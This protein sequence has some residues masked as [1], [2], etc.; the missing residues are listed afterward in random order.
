MQTIRQIRGFVGQLNVADWVTMYRI[1]AAPIMV[2]AIINGSLDLFKWLIVTSLASDMLDGFIARRLKISSEHGASL[3]S[4]GDA[5]LFVIALIGI[6]RF[7]S[8]FVAEN[9]VI[10]SFALNPY[11]FQ[12]G[13]AFW[14]YGKPSSF[15]TYMAK[16][17]AIFQGSLILF[18]LFFGINYWLFY[19]TLI[20]SILETVEEII[21]IL[22]IPKWK[23]NVKGLYWVLRNKEEYLQ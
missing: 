14:K 16:L 13:L 12:L 3:D 1:V 7:E 22:V 23:T 19:I 6:A 10:I 8:T 9:L 4:I 20:L 2:Y 11:F 18:I 17:A 5:M 21:L 15:H